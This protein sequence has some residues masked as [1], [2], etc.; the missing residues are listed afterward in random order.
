[1]Q[2]RYARIF[3]VIVILLCGLETARLWFLAPD[4]M[5]SHFNMQGNPDHYVPKLEFFGFQAQTVLVVLVL[6]LVIQVLPLIIPLKWINMPNREYWLAPERRDITAD[7]MSS[8]GA[9]LLRLYCLGYKLVLNW[10][11]LPTCINQLY[12]MPS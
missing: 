3:F 5:A 10:Q 6:S 7:L 4:V 8:Y 9:I 12:L 1:M 11:S 2:M